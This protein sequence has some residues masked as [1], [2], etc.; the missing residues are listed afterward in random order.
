MASG[1]DA[2]YALARV[3]GGRDATLAAMNAQARRLG[4]HDTVAKDPSGLDAPGQTS[5]AYDLA[6]IGRAAL[7]L[8]AFRTYVT[9]KHTPFPGRAGKGGKRGEPTSSPTTTGCSTTTRARSAS[10]TATPSPRSAPTSRPSAAGAR[11]TSSPRC[12]ASTPAGAPRPRCTTGRSA[13][14]TGSGR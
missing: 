10:R 2:A 5:S 14:P 8:P 4:A 9:T 3:G 6:L 7:Q 11:P 12:T 13:T 1:N